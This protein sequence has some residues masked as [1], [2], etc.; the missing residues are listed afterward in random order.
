MEPRTIVER[1]EMIDCK[2]KN[3]CREFESD[4][5]LLCVNNLD[6]GESF[7][8]DKETFQWYQKIRGES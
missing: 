3:A 1:L 5:C 8:V 2:H 7:F 6:N 4:R